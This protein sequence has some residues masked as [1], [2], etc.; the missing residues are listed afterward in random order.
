MSH[1]AEPMGTR[2]LRIFSP[3]RMA[4]AESLWPEREPLGHG[5]ALASH[6]HRV[7][8]FER[9][10]GDKHVVGGIEEEEARVV[11]GL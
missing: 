7:A 2:Y 11:H 3:V 8:G 6:G 4:R 5:H 1:V 9:L 10:D